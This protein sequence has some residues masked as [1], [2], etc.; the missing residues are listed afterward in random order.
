MVSAPWLSDRLS[1]YSAVKSKSVT[2]PLPSQSGHM[3]PWYTALGT[4]S[5]SP[6]SDV[7]DPLAVRLGTLN[8]KAVGGPMLGCPSLLNRIR[9]NALASVA[10]PTVERGLAP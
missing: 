2:E 8:E 1:S 3:P 5:R 6:V 7:I 4:T 10:V 9:N